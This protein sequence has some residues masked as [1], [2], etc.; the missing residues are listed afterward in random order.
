ML[1]PAYPRQSSTSAG[2]SCARSPRQHARVALQC[3]YAC[4]SARR[5]ASA[6]KEINPH[7][8]WENCERFPS[9][10]AYRDMFTTFY[11]LIPVKYFRLLAPD[12][13]S[14]WIKFQDYLVFPLG[15]HLNLLS[16]VVRVGRSPRVGREEDRKWCS[17]FWM[18]T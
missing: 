10:M 15:G 4:H 13:Y 3:S 14:V 18:L 6:A 8:L 16:S 12:H 5:R 17:V 9:I 11:E 7:Q 2:E 1:L